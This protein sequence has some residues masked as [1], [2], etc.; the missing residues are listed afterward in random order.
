VGYIAALFVGN[1]VV[2]GT[3]HGDAFGKL[4]PQEQNGQ[5]ESG[6]LDPTTGRFFTEE[7]DFYLKQIYLV[8]H[9]EAEGQHFHASLTENGRQQ[10]VVCAEF[11]AAQPLSEFE[12][13]CSPLDRC[14]QTAQIISEITAI[15]YNV[16]DCLQ[17]QRDDEPDQKFIGRIE[18]AL[19]IIHPKALIISHT[20]FILN[21]MRESIGSSFIEGITCVPNCAVAMI[22]ARRLVRSFPKQW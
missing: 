3:N 17:K 9:G 19:E 2:T 6:F 21:F 4:N 7:Y 12:L 15:P 14:V 20:D 5:I 18:N 8:R 11:L 10:C 1:R 22:D 13:Y 16:L